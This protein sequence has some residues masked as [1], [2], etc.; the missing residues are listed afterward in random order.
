MFSFPVTNTIKDGH[1]IKEFVEQYVKLVTDPD[2]S[3]FQKVLEM[4]GLRKLD[5]TAYLEIFKTVAPS[6]VASASDSEPAGSPAKA[7]AGHL[8][9][10]A[11]AATMAAT[12]TAASGEESRIKKLERL[13]KQGFDR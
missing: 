12:G 4:K 9:I 11:A 6:A 5:Q 13:I 10:E 8:D 7:V 3:E 2:L 1:T